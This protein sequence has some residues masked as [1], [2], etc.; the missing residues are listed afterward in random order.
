MLVPKST[1]GVGGAIRNR[2]DREVGLT[3][4]EVFGRHQAISSQRSPETAV[5]V[6]N[7]QVP[8]I[9]HETQPKGTHRVPVAAGRLWRRWYD[10]LGVGEKWSW[11][12]GAEY[13]GES[14]HNRT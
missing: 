7:D 13:H 9:V 5:G 10:S 14:L 12:F 8:R 1:R 4:R 6:L 2:F 3:K 11:N